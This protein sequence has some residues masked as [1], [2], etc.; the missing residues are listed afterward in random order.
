MRGLAGHDSAYD[1]QELLFRHGLE[2]NG[3][4]AAR[5]PAVRTSPAPATTSASPAPPS[6]AHRAA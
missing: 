6:Q 4:G 1:I 3:P 5:L 2:V